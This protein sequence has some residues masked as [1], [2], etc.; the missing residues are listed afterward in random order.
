MA[1]FRVGDTVYL[2]QGLEKAEP[3]AFTVTETVRENGVD[4]VRVNHPTCP[5]GAWEEKFFDLTPSED[6]GRS[7]AIVPADPKPAPIDAGPSEK[8]YLSMDELLTAAVAA[9]VSKDDAG[10]VDL[11]TKAIETLRQHRET[12]AAR[13]Q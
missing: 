2:R 12:A 1:R 4:Y 6:A 11:V 10:A 13:K 8:F 9:W 7:P 5:E 3:R